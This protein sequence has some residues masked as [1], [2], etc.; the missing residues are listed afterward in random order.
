M[1]GNKLV[2]ILTAT[3]FAA[4]VLTAI[5]PMEVKAEGHSEGCTGADII[6][7][8]G[9]DNHV[10]ICNGCNGIVSSHIPVAGGSIVKID[11]RYH[12]KKCTVDGCNLAVARQEHSYV[13][14]ICT[15]CGYFG[16]HAG[17]NIKKYEEVI[18]SNH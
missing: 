13:D 6:W 17:Y 9:D 10:A 2:K 11:S 5:A 3:L 8:G 14:D 1:K 7:L 18:V 15:V 4:T 16:P 12:G